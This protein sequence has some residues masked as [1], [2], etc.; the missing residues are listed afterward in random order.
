MKI[1]IDV[2]EIFPV[3]S[4]GKEKFYDEDMPYGI[5]Q[6]KYNWIIRVEEEYEEVQKFL[7]KLIANR[8]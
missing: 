6:Q 8:G 3:L 4:I 5:S 2:N 7:D 1:Y